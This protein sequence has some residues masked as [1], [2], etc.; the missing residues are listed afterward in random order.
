MACP[1]GFDHQNCPVEDYCIPL[2][3]NVNI[4]F[5]SFH[6]IKQIYQKGPLGNDGNPCPNYC[7]THCGPNE[8]PCCGGTDQNGCAMPDICIPTKSGIKITKNID[9]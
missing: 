2:E 1:G 3:G 7:P 9:V 5:N 6:N 4:V 8:M